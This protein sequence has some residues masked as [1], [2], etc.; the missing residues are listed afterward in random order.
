[1]VR[2]GPALDACFSRDEPPD[3]VVVAQ[4]WP[5]QFSRGD[6][7]RLMADGPL[8]R[9][10]CVY[11]PWCESDGRS[12]EIWPAGVR[13]P[14]ERAAGRLRHELA[15][16]CGEQPPIPWTATRD[17]LLAVDYAI[18][19]TESVPRRFV[20]IR[21]VDRVYREMLSDALIAA[22]FLID[23][24]GA[25]ALNLWDADPWMS[26]RQAEFTPERQGGSSKIHIALTSVPWQEPELLA[27][28]FS[29]VVSK[30][31]PA[32]VLIAALR[33]ASSDERDVPD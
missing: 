5:D 24:G 18:G 1:M 17:E 19:G 2:V 10:L 28:G 30:L 9:L 26:A 4:D 15:V 33:A 14:L 31:A 23:E 32:P 8:A 16:I 25:A 11:G 20:A 7:Q 21:A 27:A 13:V 29:R 12:R 6:V 3:L 22:G